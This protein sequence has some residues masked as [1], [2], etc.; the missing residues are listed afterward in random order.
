ME[1]V[2]EKFKKR[3]RSH[4]L[5]SKDGKFRA[6]VIKNTEAAQSAMHRH[7]LEGIASLYLAKTLSAASLLSMFLKGEERTIIEVLSDTSIPR[8][9]AE[10]IQLGEVRG[11]AELTLEY[12]PDSHVDLFSGF[13]RV[14]RILYN[15]PEPL[16]GIVPLNVGDISSDLAYYLHQSEQIPSTVYIDA[17]YGDDG[18]IAASGGII[19]QAL[20]GT[21]L[22]EILEI[23]K[24]LMSE[25]NIL[26]IIT[27]STN[28][29]KVLEKLLPFEFDV[30]KS[31]PI[32]FYCRCSKEGFISKLILL[33]TN[34]I[35]D[36]KKSNHTELRC[37][38]CNAHYYLE[39]A[40]FLNILT[41]IKSK[42][43]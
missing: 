34:E 22:N 33:D 26:N 2:K 13:L 41:S 42:K 29:I 30:V 10:A 15:K 8:I 31:T 7:N 36:M 28:N 24:R 14:T 43:N 25:R 37:Q 1:S 20:P 11:F 19:V 17:E 4:R 21:T 40:D 9:F 39:E 35:E 16:T 23:E 12:R 27:E 3:D 18:L 6:A 38:Y 32:D 5:L